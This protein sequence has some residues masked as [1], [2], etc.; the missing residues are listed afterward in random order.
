M[1]LQYED[2]FENENEE[3]VNLDDIEFSEGEEDL[4]TSPFDDDFD[5]VDVEDDEDSEDEDYDYSNEDS[6][7]DE[8]SDLETPDEDSSSSIDLDNLEFDEDFE[9]DSPADEFSDVSEDEDDVVSE[10]SSVVTTEDSLFEEI[11]ATEE[12]LK[13]DALASVEDL[14]NLL[15]DVKYER[16]YMDAIP[17]NSIV[18]SELV[19]SLRSKTIKG[20]T[21]SVSD[22]SGILNPIDVIE[23]PSLD[24]DDEKQY[25][26]ISGLRR[27]Y[28]TIRNNIS[29]IPAFVWKFADFEKASKLAFLLGL[30][31]NK[32]QAHDMEETWY[33]MQQLERDYNLKPANIE[34]LF[35]NLLPGDAMRL[36]D[37][38]LGE[39]EE[40]KNL[41]FS[42]EKT[43]DASYK[44][45]QKLRKEEDEL[46]S[47]DSQG[48]LSDTELGR[49]A[50]VDDDNPDDNLSH[51]DVMSI[52]EMEDEIDLS[53]S[54]IFNE[55]ADEGYVQDRRGDGDD[56][57][58]TD[59][60]NRIKT[61][62][63]MLCR[64]CCSVGVVQDEEGNWST[65]EDPKWERIDERY[66]EDAAAFLS[67][68]TVHHIIPN[69][70][71]GTDDDNNLITLCLLCHHR[72]H[73]ME[74]IGKILVDEETFKHMSI[75]VQHDVLGAFYFARKAI[76][77]GVR[78]GH[79]RKQRQELA[80]QS[81]RH[82]FPGRDI[83]NDGALLQTLEGR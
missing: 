49:D 73:V 29:T 74:K 13:A 59:A 46:E 54:E 16:T 8:N 22:T 18:A 17:I 66:A 6:E 14:D 63:K 9:D 35:P 60:K 5:V 62:D 45:L 30:F 20:L 53:D 76:E 69:H 21:A 2:E 27:M 41:L 56:D 24:D 72:L 61:R 47:E 26:I 78:K 82:K 80:S 42:G 12:E 75:K 44:L 32:Q 7:F 11:P 55:S 10:S 50:V 70:A 77:A 28:A 3:Q 19:K 31:I 83:K 38:A 1:K 68:L 48:I 43:L 40:P 36:K 81:L 79:N 4:G 58:S 15:S 52:L 57:L 33:A 64:V 23:M 65:D 51:A 37:V 25:M 34:R 39:F 67:T 71:G